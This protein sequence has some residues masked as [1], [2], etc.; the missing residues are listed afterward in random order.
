MNPSI[1]AIAPKN[2]TGID[3]MDAEHAYLIDLDSIV[4]LL[5]HITKEDDKY[6]RFI[7]GKPTAVVTRPEAMTAASPMSEPYGSLALRKP[8]AP[9]S[10]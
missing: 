9:D 8:T 6:A 10:R 1:E 3:K 4:L 2:R 7:L 5:E